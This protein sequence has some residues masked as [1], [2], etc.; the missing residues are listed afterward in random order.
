MCKF[1]LMGLVLL[2]FVGTVVP[3]AAG[4]SIT[5]T[6]DPAELARVLEH[7][8]NPPG[9]LVG[10]SFV[11]IPPAGTPHGIGSS[12]LG[13]FPTS[14]NEFLIMTTGNAAFAGQPNDSNG[15]GEGI[16]GESVRGDTDRDVSVLRIDLDV[17]A[18]ANC[19]SLD[20]RF[21][22]EE[23]P[24][25]VGS[26][27]NDAFIAE[28]DAST[29]TTSGS[30][31]Q[32]PGNFAFDPTG[33]PI[34]INSVGST[35]MT[36]GEAIGTT[37]DG[38][39]PV[40]KAS[41]PITPGSHALYLSI[42]DQGDN[43]YDSAVF[44]DRLVLGTTTA[45]GCQAGA[46][47]LSVTKATSTPIVFPSGTVEY[48]ISVNNPS[49]SA[50]ELTSITDSLPA[51]FTYVSDSTTGATDLEP[52]I[53]GSDLTWTGAFALPASSSV[54][55]RFRVTA[56]TVLGEHWNNAGATAIGASVSPSGPT[57]MVTVIEPPCAIADLPEIA[58]SEAEPC[59]VL[60][61]GAVC[62]ENATVTGEEVSSETEAEEL[63]PG[64]TVRVIRSKTGQFTTTAT[65]TGTVC[66]SEC[67]DGCY[68][69]C[70]GVP[71]QQC[72]Q[73]CVRRCVN[74]VCFEWETR[75]ELSEL[76]SQCADQCFTHCSENVDP[77]TSTSFF[78][79]SC[80]FA[81]VGNV[82]VRAADG[83]CGGSVIAVYELS[84][85]GTVARNIP[86]PLTPGDYELCFDGTLLN[87]VAVRADCGVPACSL[88]PA[89][90]RLVLTRG[91]SDAL[92]IELANLSAGGEYAL[93][94]RRYEDDAH[95]IELSVAPFLFVDTPAIVAE[96]GVVTFDLVATNSQP[97][98]EQW[99]WTNVMLIADGPARCA[100]GIDV[101][102]VPDCEGEECESTPT[103]TPLAGTATPATPTEGP[104][105]TPT[106]LVVCGNG[107]VESDEQCDPGAPVVGDCCSDTCEFESVGASC[108]ADAESCTLDL[109]DDDGACVTDAVA[110]DGASCDDLS[111]CTENDVCASGQCA[112]VPLNCDDGIACTTDGCN[113]FVGCVNVAT[114]ES[115]DCPGSCSDGI[116]ND[117][118][119]PGDPLHDPNKIDS[120]NDFDLEDSGCATLAPM[121]RFAVVGTR[122]RMHRDLKL[123][124]NTTVRATRVNG[125]CNLA[126][127]QCECPSVECG[128]VVTCSSNSDCSVGTCN[129][130]TKRCE[131]AV[132]CP[133]AGN[134]CSGDGGCLF[135]VDGAC[136]LQTGRC[137][138]PP[139]SPNCQPLGR[140]CSSDGGCRA[141]P[142]P[143]GASL[144]GVC[145]NGM[146]I[147]AGTQIG[148]LASATILNKLQ[149]GTAESGDGL[150]TLDIKREFASA[151]G[152]RQLSSPA[153][154]VGPWVCSDDSS[155]GCTADG[156]CA[157]GT[158]TGRRRLGDGSPFETTDG[159][160][161]AG[162]A[163]T[164]AS[165]N[166]KRCDV[167]L[168]GLRSGGTASPSSLQAGIEAYVPTV[169]QEV[170]LG[171]GN[172]LVCAGIDSADAACTPCSI[173]MANVQ[174]REA[175]KK[176]VLTVGSGLKVIDLRRLALAGK[177]RLVLR[178]TA[179]TEL[180][181]R[182]DRALRTGT[183]SGVVLEGMTSS[184]VLF[185]AIG[186]LGGRPRIAG[187]STWRGSI[188]ATERRAGIMLGA[189]AY[190]EGSIF[191]QRVLVKGPNTTIQH[192]PWKGKV[193]SVP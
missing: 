28:I 51:G 5:L 140:P 105:F 29:W 87:S 176:I 172:C 190:L 158:C 147:T 24:E 127:Q 9:S 92:S 134:S 35:L 89:A 111:A 49:A 160:P 144:G 192:H 154:F 44:L 162:L 85:A 26:S 50:V 34:T 69:N 2:V 170:V 177:T 19:L 108:A 39:T 68:V 157:N 133:V 74:G 120:D 33:Q 66:G 97:L 88:V 178:G 40:L 17:P 124:S 179:D 106:P 149:F 32:A 145:G 82:E 150:R 191:G 142:Y 27:F 161:G 21:F 139:D 100:V 138:C 43:A 61:S 41:T 183:G 132:D 164:G 99:L 122:D 75:C 37:Y 121:A 6:S 156:D 165:E 126:T 65:V 63:C 101:E 181:L 163:G 104:V 36:A 30:T 42:F 7:S 189:G 171:P 187:A 25:F 45:A 12:G 23:Y 46:T 110:V 115:R 91:A 20:F 52:T 186:R 90:P 67:F 59:A 18:G 77:D 102:I 117:P 79:Q 10:A 112:G 83:A 94:L 48:E 14:G 4:A 185:V 80:G 71:L 188:L 95:T 166:F 78:E 3:G 153:P 16:S 141:A 53:S 143:A 119:D 129:S 174:T 135:E 13:G 57:A 96:N 136:N 1:S 114:V 175:N 168:A 72:Y 70:V 169:A 123:G 64:S 107:A 159:V 62:P 125:S 11:H 113:P 155:R 86:L 109:C 131:C 98:G 93:S 60:G 184:Q 128:P 73:T 31:I 146:Q 47:V 118:I 173:G 38:A 103:P 152:P 182:V 116:N 130:A 148:L 193:P 167:S 56:A 151:G 15:D 55:L 180:M 54:S 84:G 58:C 81:I 8:T 76:Q 22:S 137:A